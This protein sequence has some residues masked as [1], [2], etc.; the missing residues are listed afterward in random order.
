[1]IRHGHSKYPAFSYMDFMV[2]LVSVVVHAHKYG[3]VAIANNMGH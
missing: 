3:P 2:S 1:M